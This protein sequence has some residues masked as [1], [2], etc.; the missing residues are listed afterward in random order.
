M[1]KKCKV[2][3]LAVFA[4]AS[5]ASPALAQSSWTTGTA[6][7][8]AGAGFA[9]PYTNVPAVASGHA[10]G[11]R[12]F[13]MVPRTGGGGRYSAAADGGGSLGY[14]WTLEHDY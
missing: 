11:L 10:S 4:A 12:A 1:I 2:A 14:N 3:A 5:I 9:S 8:M 13:A 7:D 6:S